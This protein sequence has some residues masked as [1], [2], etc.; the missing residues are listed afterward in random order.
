M[1]S[2]YSGHRQGEGIVPTTNAG[3][4]AAKAEVLRK[5][6]GPQG[7]CRFESGRP[8]QYFM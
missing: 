8:H 7:L 4:A 5:F 2:T 6:V 1:G 3:W